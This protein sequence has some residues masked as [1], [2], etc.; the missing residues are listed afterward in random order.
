MVGIQRPAVLDLP[1]IGSGGHLPIAMLAGK[2]ILRHVEVHS[3]TRLW[4]R[5][6]VFDA[7]NRPGALLGCD[8]AQVSRR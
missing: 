4:E 8:L 1:R 5:S 2:F 3:I 6:A 7:G